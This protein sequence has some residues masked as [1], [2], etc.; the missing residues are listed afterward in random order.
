MMNGLSQSVPTGR[1]YSVLYASQAAADALTLL[2][3]WWE[4][5]RYALRKHAARRRTPK[6]ERSSPSRR[7]DG[8]RDPQLRRGRT[9]AEPFAGLNGLERPTLRHHGLPGGAK[10]EGTILHDNGR[11]AQRPVPHSFPRGPGGRVPY[12]TSHHDERIAL[13]HD[14]V[15]RPY[16]RRRRDRIRDTRLNRVGDKRLRGCEML[17]V[18]IAGGSRGNASMPQAGVKHTSRPQ[19]LS[20]DVG[21]VPRD[22][23]G[24]AASSACIEV[25]LRR[26]LPQSY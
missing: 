3:G 20:I 19:P 26:S 5:E 7:R 17:E 4:F 21:L 1:N 16:R 24:I 23:S 15:G 12:A 14:G 11:Q 22:C 8:E 25:R 13:R 2:R 6:G 18:R 9:A 10:K